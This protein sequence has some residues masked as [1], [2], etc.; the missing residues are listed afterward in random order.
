M[1]NSTIHGI[2]FN[3]FINFFVPSH[4]NYRKS[5]IPVA[6]LYHHEFRVKFYTKND[7]TTPILG[8]NLFV[9]LGETVHLDINFPTFAGSQTVDRSFLRIMIDLKP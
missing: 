3:N 5:V 8:N 4:I 6:R 7:H 1:G 9:A 2:S